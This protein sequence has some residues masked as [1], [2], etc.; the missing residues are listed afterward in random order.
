MGSQPSCTPK[1][2]ISSSAS[3][4]S[5]VAKP[6]KTKTVVT[7]SKS[8][9]CRVADSTPMG[10]AS[11]HDDQHLD[12]LRSRVMGRRS[13]ILVRTGRPS[14]RNERPKSSRTTRA[15]PVPVLHVQ[16]LVEPVHLAQDLSRLRDVPL[17]R[18]VAAS[19]SR[20]GSP[21]AR[22]ITMNEMKVMPIRSGIGEQEPRGARRARI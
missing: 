15:Q 7:L 8:E 12:T 2:I 1:R 17:G 14:G 5:G 4:K 21:G 22:W 9:Y 3:Q 6:T 19:G 18:Q 11:G 10:T 20:A 16:R 13:P